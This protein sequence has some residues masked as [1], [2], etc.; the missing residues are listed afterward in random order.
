MGGKSCRVFHLCD[1]LSTVQN[2]H[3]QNSYLGN[4]IGLAFRN[5]VDAQRYLNELTYRQCACVR[6]HPY[7]ASV[8][9]NS[10]NK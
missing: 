10:N 8:S 7:V 6:A 4:Q 5:E 9:A 3:D 1:L 2:N